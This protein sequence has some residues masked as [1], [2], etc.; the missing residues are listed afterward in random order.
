MVIPEARRRLHE[1]LDNLITGRITNWQFNKVYSE[2]GCSQD[3]AVAVISRFGWGLYSDS[4]TYRITEH[5]RIKPQT[6]AMAERCL[7]FLRTN[8]EYAWPEWPNQL[9]Q[10]LARGLAYKLFPAGVALILVSLPLFFLALKNSKDGIYFLGCCVPG[11]VIL[12]GCFW[13]WRWSKTQDSPSWKE[14]WASGDQEAWPFLKR[15]EY[16]SAMD[17]VSQNTCST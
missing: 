7:L 4:V 10:G 13:M 14:F 8:L 1:G 15:T 16:R 17:L 12:L 11:S 3:R 5:Y 9:W 6:R 2:L